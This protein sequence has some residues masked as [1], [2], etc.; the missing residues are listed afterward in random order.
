MGLIT[1]NSEKRL[2]LTQ[3]FIK[4]AITIALE[5]LNLKLQSLEINFISA[6]EIHE[7]NKKYLN[8]DYSTDI[9]TF[10]YS[11]EG[12]NLIEGELFISLDDARANSEEYKVSFASELLRLV[13]H[14]ILHLNGMDDDTPEKRSEMQKEEDHLLS[15]TMG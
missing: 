10:D 4:S 9:I 2:P 13:F 14:G 6:A 11:D 8:H 3:K 5:K 1:I 7:I 15:L 12:S